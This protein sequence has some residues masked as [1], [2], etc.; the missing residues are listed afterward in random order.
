LIRDFHFCGYAKISEEL[1]SF[2]MEFY[3]KNNIPLDA[4][5]TGKMMFGIFDLIKK[6]DFPKGSKI[7]AIHTGGLQGNIGFNERLG[8]NL[9]HNF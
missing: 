6:D 7:L 5:Y 3:D 8:L 1:I 4:I 2:I 9:P